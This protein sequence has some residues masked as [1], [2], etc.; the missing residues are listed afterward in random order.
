MEQL[1]R[2]LL[3]HDKLIAV[4][5]VSAKQLQFVCERFDN[6]GHS[7]VRCRRSPASTLATSMIDNLELPRH[8]PHG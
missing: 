5:S 2:E 1:I 8:R 6:V 4:V 7:G 3:E